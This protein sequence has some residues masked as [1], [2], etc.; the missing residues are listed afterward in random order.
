MPESITEAKKFLAAGGLTWKEL[1]NGY[2]I[3]RAEKTYQGVKQ[4]WLLVRSQQAYERE[5]KTLDRHIDKEYLEATKALAPIKSTEFGC[6][7]DAHQSLR[8]L[9]KLKYHTLSYDLE[10][11]RKYKQRGRPP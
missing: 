6:G 3:A 11:M 4:R 1:E 2:R 8:K 10:K 7:K 9:P 5:I